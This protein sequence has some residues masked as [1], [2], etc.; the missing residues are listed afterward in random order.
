M[1]RPNWV[2]GR[3]ALRQGLA[4]VAGRDRSFDSG[5][6]FDL[7]GDTPDLAGFSAVGLDVS[8]DLLGDARGAPVLPAGFVGSISHKTRLAIALVARADGWTRGVDLEAVMPAPRAVDLTGRI[9]T[10]A[11]RQNLLQLPESERAAAVLWG[12]CA[13]EAIYKA[14]DPFVHRYVG[15]HEVQVARLSDG[16]GDAMLQLP[17]AE[18][19]FDVDLRWMVHDGWNI[20][21][22]RVRRAG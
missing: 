15:F 16:T 2:A 17:D 21:S 9:M 10:P 5:R 1:R 3:L 7:S 20:T 4:A 22:A 14:L 18:G 13:K 6:P 8:G 12:F 19:P 11:E